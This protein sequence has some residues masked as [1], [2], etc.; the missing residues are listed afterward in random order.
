MVNGEPV[1]I[2]FQVAMTIAMAPSEQT[3]RYKLKVEVARQNGE[4]GLVMP[5][6]PLIS[7]VKYGDFT[8]DDLLEDGQPNYDKPG[9]GG[10]V[11]LGA[12][13]GTKDFMAHHA[14][15]HS[16]S[17]DETR[18]PPAFA[19]IHN[20]RVGI[21]YRGYVRGGR[22]IITSGCREIIQYLVTPSLQLI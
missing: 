4:M 14:G 9:V 19:S 1:P 15:R 8:G 11:L 18:R 17:P 16:Q 22:K 3:R 5:D 21:F 10:S 12:I 6:I 13:H 2:G 20:C 7:T